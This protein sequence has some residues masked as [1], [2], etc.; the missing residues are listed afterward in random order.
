MG[1]KYLIV[2]MCELFPASASNT[3][4]TAYSYSNSVL[5]S[6]PLNIP[7]DSGSKM[8]FDSNS[9]D[10]FVASDTS[11]DA[12]MVNSRKIS[13]GCNPGRISRFV[14]KYLEY[15]IFL[16][17]FRIGFSPSFNLTHDSGSKMCSDS[18]SADTFVAAD[19]S[20]DARMV[21]KRKKSH[22]CNV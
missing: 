13:N 8:C 10:T 11:T 4:N 3:W 19:T 15:G 20:T 16:L 5:G 18:H 14:T 2:A 1:E 21:N 7:H 9:A 17:E 12:R 22:S 6:L